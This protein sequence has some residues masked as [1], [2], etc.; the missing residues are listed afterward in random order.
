MSLYNDS[1]LDESVSVTQ[2][3]EAR[4]NRLKHVADAW[5]VALLIIMA[6]VSIVAFGLSFFNGIPQ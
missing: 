2:W 6:T 1:E 5:P 4:Y 3:P